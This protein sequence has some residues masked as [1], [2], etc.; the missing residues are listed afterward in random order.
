VN[1]KKERFF[2]VF[3]SH[4]RY[5]DSR[6]LMEINDR[7]RGCIQIEQT[8][9]SIYSDF[10]NRFPVEKEFWEGLFYDEVE[11]A[12]FMNGVDYLKIIPGLPKEVSL[13]E[14]P[15]IAKTMEYALSV[16]NQI[17][18]K[19]F[20]LEDALKM[21]LILEESMVETFM[22]ELMVVLNSSDDKS[23]SRDFE[24]MLIEERGHVSKI[25]NMM[26]NK[27]YLKMT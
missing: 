5:N 13:P 24:D 11:H 16:Q 4:V 23:Y 18:F 19:Q 27:G 26:L 1:L 3:R 7:I 21:S 2:L 8:I 14:S 10:M 15:Y 25:K 9:A 6:E 22:N 12:S 20:S 17:K